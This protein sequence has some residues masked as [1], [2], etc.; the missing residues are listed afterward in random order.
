MC[1]LQLLFLYIFQNFTSS[2]QKDSIKITFGLIL[3]TFTSFDCGSFKLDHKVRKSLM[4]ISDKFNIYIRCFRLN[5][6]IRLRSDS[7]H[8]RLDLKYTLR[9]LSDDVFI[10]KS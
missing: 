7:N 9:F 10:S 5:S 4:Q 3:H 8:K 1:F 6:N 2:F